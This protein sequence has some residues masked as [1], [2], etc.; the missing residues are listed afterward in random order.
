MFVE[1]VL[2]VVQ[3][4]PT[5]RLEKISTN[6]LWVLSEMQ[7]G[8]GDLKSSLTGVPACDPQAEYLKSCYD[9]VSAPD[10]SEFP[11]E[12]LESTLDYS[13]CSLRLLEL[14]AEYVPPVT[15]WSELALPQVSPADFRPTKSSTC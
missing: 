12:L 4:D 15:Q 10:L 11:A 3:L 6:T 5:K 7:K 2:P 13:N 9:Y 14:Q 8:Y 1:G